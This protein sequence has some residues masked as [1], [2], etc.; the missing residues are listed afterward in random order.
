VARGLD[1][2]A[3]GVD[4]RRR[5]LVRDVA[6][7]HPRRRVAHVGVVAAAV[8]DPGIDNTDL[9][10][11]ARA[12]GAEG[13]HRA[14]RQRGDAD[15]P[16]AAQAVRA[17]RGLTVGGEVGGGLWHLHIDEPAAGATRRG[18]RL[19]VADGRAHLAERDAARAE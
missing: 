2:D 17:D 4:L 12:V 13:R 9:D 11:A 18:R 3:A 14:G 5:T 8:G 7:L 19:A 10:E 6:D 1:V 16:P 15:V